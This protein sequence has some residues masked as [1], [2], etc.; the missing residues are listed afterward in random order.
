MESSA[1][2]SCPLLGLSQKVN[3]QRWTEPPSVRCCWLV[4]TYGCFF[5]PVV[6][7][8]T[9]GIPWTFIALILKLFM[10]DS[11][12]QLDPGNNTS[13]G[14]S[15]RVDAG[16]HPW[17]PSLHVFTHS[18][19]PQSLGQIFTNREGTEFPKGL[20][21]GCTGPLPESPWENNCLLSLS[22]AQVHNLTCVPHLFTL[23][24]FPLQALSGLLK[25]APYFC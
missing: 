22:V 23:K 3:W 9:S 14:I 8:K 15:Q 11:D 20:A 16:P 10:A 6:V 12:H 2:D 17:E 13:Y 1:V 25:D 4:V 19:E 21:L 5:F 7:L 24:E 18:W